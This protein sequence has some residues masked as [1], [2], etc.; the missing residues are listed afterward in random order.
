MK[1]FKMKIKEEWDNKCFLVYG[2]LSTSIGT[3]W[4]TEYGYQKW[5]HGGGVDA[6]EEEDGDVGVQDPEG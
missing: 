3:P 5:I 2:C 6:C 4:E 1:L